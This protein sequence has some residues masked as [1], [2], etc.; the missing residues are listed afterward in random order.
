MR[1]PGSRRGRRPPGYGW[2]PTF[3]GLSTRRQWLGFF[4]GA[5]VVVAVAMLV[6]FLAFG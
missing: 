3:S 2:D 4:L 5:V 6:T 1:L